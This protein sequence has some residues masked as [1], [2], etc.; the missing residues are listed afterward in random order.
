V[1]ERLVSGAVILREVT[2]PEGLRLEDTLALLQGLDL[3]IS[4]DLGVEARR[5]DLVADL[6]PDAEDLEGYL[7]P[8]TYS[9]PRGVAAG[10]VVRVLVDRFRSVASELQAELGPPAAGIRGWV[11]LA[12]LVEKETGAADERHRLAGVFAN[13]LRLGMPLQ[14]DP[15]VIYALHKAQQPRSGS[16]ARHLDIDHPYNTYRYPGLPPGPIANPGREALAA[17]L[18]PA[19]SKDLYFV[20]DGSGGHRFSRT[21][22]EHNQAVREWRRLSSGNGR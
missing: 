7:F 4:G 20:A 15:T 21:L 12:S 18:R 5:G 22:A 10:V 11:T 8:D 3:A 9:F 14:C 19:A 1:L 17:A 13:R 2:I 6:D 16:L